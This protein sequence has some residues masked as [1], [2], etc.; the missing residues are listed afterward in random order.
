MQTITTIVFDLGGVLLDLDQGKTLRA[1]KRLGV[2]LE[3]I[4]LESTVFTDY[5]TGKLSSEDFLQ[6]INTKLKGNASSEQITEAWNAMLLGITAER[7]QFLEQLRKTFRVYLLSNTN[8]IHIRSVHQYLSTTFGLDR[9]NQLFDHQ[10]LSYEMGS[11][12]PDA[13]CYLQVLN[14]IGKQPQE[15]LFIDDSHTNI[16]GATKVGIHTLLATAPLDERMMQQIKDTVKAWHQL[17]RS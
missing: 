1:F 11:R 6:F 8:E 10:F 16:R 15:V 7:F 4:N 13:A 12:K 5:E 14:H 17:Q 9:W 2:D 3:D